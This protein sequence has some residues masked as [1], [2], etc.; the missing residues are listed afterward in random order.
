MTLVPL[1]IDVAS[2]TTGV[3]IV[4]TILFDATCWPIPILLS[5]LRDAVEKNV[6]ELAHNI[7]ADAEVSGMGRTI[8]HF[9]GRADLYTKALHDQVADQ[10]RPQLYEVLEDMQRLSKQPKNVT[11]TIHLSLNT[12][13]VIIQDSFDW[14]SSISVSPIVFAEQM[15]SELNLPD[16]AA[17]AIATSILEQLHGLDMPMSLEGSK[18]NV[19][20]ELD[21]KEHLNQVSYIVGL[22]R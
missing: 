19:V 1:R 6:Q 8:R 11:T 7:V 2:S 5:S 4:D 10:L 14:D 18:Q 21:P 15:A 22:H 17:V 3:R 16:E 9:T 20:K 12:H 13:G